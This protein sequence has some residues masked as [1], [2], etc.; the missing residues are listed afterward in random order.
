MLTTDKTTAV[1]QYFDFSKNNQLV[2]NNKTN[3]LFTS[4]DQ[5]AS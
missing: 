3:Q 4:D 5:N 1:I 2:A